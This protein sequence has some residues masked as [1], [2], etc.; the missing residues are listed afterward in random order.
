MIYIVIILIVLIIT[1]IYLN[2]IYQ[3]S[4]LPCA[5]EG[6]YDLV[7]KKEY[8]DIF[9]CYDA[10]CAIAKGYDC[11]Q[12][13]DTI[14]EPGAQENCRMSCEDNTDLMIQSSIKL[15]NYIF[16]KIPRSFGK[17]SLL[18]SHDYF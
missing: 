17:Y 10:K 7:P 9:S 4:I 2:N 13:C 5:Y 18:N 6:F 16:G 8:S 15:D 1:F 14:D 11:Y 3:K 12:Y